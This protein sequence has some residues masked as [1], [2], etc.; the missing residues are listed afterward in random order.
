MSENSQTVTVIGAGTIG[1]AWSALFAVNQHSVRLFDVR[2][3]FESDT[4]AP[5]RRMIGQ[6]TDEVDVALGRIS[7]H[8]SLEVALEGATVVQENGPEN[9]GFK[10]NIFAE[11]EA[12]ADKDALLI[13]STSGIPPANIGEKMQNPAR[14]LIG[15]PLNPPHLMPLVEVCGTE[16]VDEALIDR[17]NAFYQSN[18]RV[19]VRLHKPVAGFVVNRLQM[20][21]LR[22]AIHLVGEGVVDIDGIDKVVLN[23]VGVRL[24]S[25]GPMLACHF[26][27]GAGG[28]REMVEKIV[29]SLFAA[30]DLPPV[31]SR[32]LDLLE[33]QA[34]KHYPLDRL[35]EFAAVRDRRQAAALDVQHK[36]PL[37]QMA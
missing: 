31:D 11:V 9:P 21:M 5:L 34:A 24:A 27:G 35:G 2:K 13:S 14:V 29:G 30:M 32:T 33:A 8:G 10:Q 7:F 23:S 12:I 15:H 37:P 22:E 28:I 19:P 20:A 17:V 18:A 26:G 3:G 4:I 16:S 25:I 1:I 36:N 6:L